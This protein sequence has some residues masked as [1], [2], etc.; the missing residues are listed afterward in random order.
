MQSCRHY[1][2]HDS[3]RLTMG[4]AWTRVKLRYEALMAESSP[5]I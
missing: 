3:F 1:Y 4:K 5:P 2:S